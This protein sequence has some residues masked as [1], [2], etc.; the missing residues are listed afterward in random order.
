MNPQLGAALQ[1]PQVRAMMANPEFLRQMSNPSTM[2][3][4][5]Q[6]QQAMRTLQG[7]GVIPPGSAGFP[8]MFPP[9]PYGAMPPLGGPPRGPAGGLDFNALFAPPPPGAGHAL[10]AHP[11]HGHPPPPQLEPSI[12]FASQLQQLQDMG[13]TDSAANL[14]ALIGT[15]GNV[16]AAVERLLGGN[17]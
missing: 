11:P 7:N 10:P 5:M 12:R 13:F 16:N 4:M 8:P 6:I 2:Q 14:R 3:A 9:G 15:N 17:F 1:N